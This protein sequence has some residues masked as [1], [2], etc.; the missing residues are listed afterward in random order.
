MYKIRRACWFHT[1]HSPTSPTFL[2]HKDGTQ[3]THLA[4][5]CTETN[6][7]P[8]HISVAQMKLLRTCV[9]YTCWVLSP[10]GHL[11]ASWL[12]S[13]SICYGQPGAVW[14][15]LSRGCLQLWVADRA[16]AHKCLHSFAW[17]LETKKA[18]KLPWMPWLT[19]LL[20]YRCAQLS[21]VH[22]QEY[23]CKKTFYKRAL[24]EHKW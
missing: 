4:V 18:L 7:H 15:W 16:G 13:C 22:F 3:L 6:P 5:P 17:I 20:T 23:S 12:L 9:I 19:M 1:A 14:R 2:L 10:Q 11:A 21:A 8:T 24:G